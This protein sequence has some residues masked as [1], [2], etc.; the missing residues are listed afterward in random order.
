LGGLIDALRGI[1]SVDLEDTCEWLYA[2]IE[3]GVLNDDI[4]HTRLS[5]LINVINVMREILIMSSIQWDE[6]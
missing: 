1:R 4:P 3:M 6:L 5:E 2:L